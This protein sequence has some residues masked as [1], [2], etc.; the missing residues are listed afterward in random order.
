MTAPS[1]S[2]SSGGFLLGV[3]VVLSLLRTAY[4]KPLPCE[5]SHLRP[6]VLT[7]AHPKAAYAALVANALRPKTKFASVVGSFGWGGKM[8]GQLTGL[9]GNLKVELIDPVVTKGHPKDEEYLALDELADR[10]LAKHKEIGI[11]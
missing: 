7:G 9:I 2:I 3:L 10:I 1:V 4:P 8:L 5:K 11:V 6:T